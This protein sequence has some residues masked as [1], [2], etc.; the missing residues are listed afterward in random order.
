MAENN[1]VQDSAPQSNTIDL[2]QNLQTPKPINKYNPIKIKRGPKKVS[3]LIK[4]KVLFEF[5]FLLITFFLSLRKAINVIMRGRI[6]KIGKTLNQKILKKKSELIGGKKE[7]KVCMCTNVKNENK[8]IK[9]FIQYYEKCGVDKIFLYDNNDSDGE[10]LD[11]IISNYISSGFVEISDWRGKEKQQLNMM[12]DCYKK[13]FDKYNWLIFYDVDE[14]I[15]LK[16]YTNIK[17]F[18]ND[19][20]FLTCKKIYLN[21]VFHTDNNL[22]NYENKSLQER[23]PE[24][25]SKPN[26]DKTFKHNLVKSIIRGNITN[27]N[28]DCPHKLSNEF[29]GCNGNGV[30]VNLNECGMEDPD[31]DNNYIDHYFCKSLD[32]FIE[33]LNMK[34][35]NK[36]ELLSIY[37]EYNKITKEKIDYLEKKTGINLSLYKNALN[38]N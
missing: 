13:N 10:K 38:E 28:I 18:L 24:K 3:L 17:Q 21:W 37:F 11:Q 31:F 30:E 19:E 12:N 23:F 5:S 25:E 14:Y 27:L 32:E 6:K 8:Y 16:D 35:V 29:K 22:I 7:I 4:M 9:E 26:K 2:T 1:Q 33:K 15:H 34:D 20:K 36:T